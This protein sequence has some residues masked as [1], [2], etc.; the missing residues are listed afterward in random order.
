MTT[1]RAILL[2]DADRSTEITTLNLSDLPAGDVLVK[3]DYSTLNYKDA[4]ALTW[5]API[6]KSFPMI[7]GIDFAGEVVES[8]HSLYTAGEKVILNG[9][10]VGEKY[11]GGLAE[12]ARVN[13]DW[14]VHLPSKLSTRD[15]MAIGTA[16]YTAMLCVNALRNHDVQPEDGPIVVT[17]ATGGV[18]SLAVYMLSQR[19]YE[20]HAMTGKPDAQ[21]EY[22]LNLGAKEVLDRDKYSAKARPLDT[23]EWAGGVDTVGSN[24]LANVLAHAKY[25]ATIACCGLAQGM[26]LPTT[27]APFILR[28]VTLVGVESVYAAKTHRDEA[29][30]DLAEVYTHD[31]LGHIAHEISLEQATEAAQQIVAGQHTGRY[32]VKM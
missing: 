27:V 21:R 12:Y 29:W 25:N 32:L 13:G 26:D 9:W 10:G 3:V 22:L 20:V 8:A 5:Q 1:F 28:A 19:G 30:A 7:P 15:A 17:G 14:L 2:N 23:Q 16:G 18:G 24:I 31:M 6:C 4:L 11:F